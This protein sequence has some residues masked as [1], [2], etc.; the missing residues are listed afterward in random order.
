MLNIFFGDMPE[1]VYNTSAY[2]NHTYM[3]NWF[4]DELT[5]KIIKAID[6]GEV[7]GANCILTKALGPIP[8]TMLAGGTKTLLLIRHK[9]DRIYNASTCGDNCAKW[10]LKIAKASD[11]DIT[12]NLRHLMHFDSKNFDIRVLNTGNIVHSMAELVIEAGQYV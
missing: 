12:V 9:T 4:D 11:K 8:P 6:K 5:K 7:Q 10:L 2:F 3:D 1:A